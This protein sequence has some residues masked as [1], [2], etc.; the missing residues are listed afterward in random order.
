MQPPTPGST[1]C[2]RKGLKP[3]LPGLNTAYPGPTHHLYL[4]RIDASSQPVPHLSC[5]LLLISATRAEVLPG[6]LPTFPPA[7]SL[8][9]PRPWDSSGARGGPQAMAS[10]CP[11]AWPPF[12]PSGRCHSQGI[13][14]GVTRT[15]SG[16]EVGKLCEL[17]KIKTKTPPVSP[18]P[19]NGGGGGQSMEGKRGVPHCDPD[20]TSP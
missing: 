2:T 13:R 11:G 8:Q 15:S 16:T 18:S 17:F 1:L 4:T 7:A 14:D 3:P 5:F 20:C 19:W 12:W 6:P 9:P 10:S